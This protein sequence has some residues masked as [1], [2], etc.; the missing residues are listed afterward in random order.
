MR[1][2]IEAIAENETMSSA[3]PRAMRVFARTKSGRRNMR[4]AQP[5]ASS[6]TATEAM[7]KVPPTTACTPSNSAP[8]ARNHSRV[9][10]RAAMSR[11]NRA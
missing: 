2:W 7:P 5:I 9:A 8:G 6:G 11:R 4:S 10:T 3:T 1:A